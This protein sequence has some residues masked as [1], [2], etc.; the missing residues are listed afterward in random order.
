MEPASSSAENE[1]VMRNND[2]QDAM[3]N[4]LKEEDIAVPDHFRNFI[5]HFRCSACNY[6]GASWMVLPCGCI[7]CEDCIDARTESDDMKC[8][9]CDKEF[10]RGE[11]RPCRDRNSQT[12]MLVVRCQAPGRGNGCEWEGKLDSREGHVAEC[13]YHPMGCPHEGCEAQPLRKD[14]DEHVEGC[15]FRLLVCQH[16]GCSETFQQRHFDEK[17]V[18][19]EGCG[20]KPVVCDLCSENMLN[21]RLNTHKEAIC[22]LATVTCAGVFIMETGG[23]QKETV[24]G[25]SEP[26][27]KLVG[28]CVWAGK[29]H[30]L[31]QHRQTCLPYITYAVVLQ[32][33]ITFKQQVEELR[34]E[35]VEL[36]SSVDQLM[37]DA[38]EGKSAYVWNYSF[39]DLES[40][41]CGS[42]I[43]SPAFYLRGRKWRIELQVWQARPYIVIP[44]VEMLDPKPMEPPQFTYT[45]KFGV[46]EF[47]KENSL[48]YARFDSVTLERPLAPIEVEISV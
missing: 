9:A 47:T 41:S 2:I 8:P 30:E 4:R 24:G 43:R 26:I 6:F 16:D 7:L 13:G 23:C 31:P 12:A 27:Q 25:N 3:G 42:H 34:K 36:K 28:S 37:M 35:N 1:F 32:Q 10:S 14:F 18:H 5:D 40:Y 39:E 29:R 15:D 44:S 38:S 11:V 20:R 17:V 33:N 21:E 22:R 48:G 45:L 46:P 19:E